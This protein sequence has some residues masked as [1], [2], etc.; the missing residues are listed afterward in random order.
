MILTD[1]VALRRNTVTVSVANSYAV[2]VSLAI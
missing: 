2:I 1:I